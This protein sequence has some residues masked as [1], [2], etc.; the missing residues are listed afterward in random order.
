M[1]ETDLPVYSS[2]DPSLDVQKRARTSITIDPELF[3]KVKQLAFDRKTSVSAVF[4][5][6]LSTYLGRSQQ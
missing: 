2:T 4:E 5:E 1:S 6:A 3:A